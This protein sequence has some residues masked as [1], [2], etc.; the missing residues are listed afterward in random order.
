MVINHY[1]RALFTKQLLPQLKN[2]AQ[3]TPLGARVISVYAPGEEGPIFEDDLELKKNFSVTMAAKILT[4]Y[5][6]YTAEHL[7]KTNPDIGFSHAYP[8]VVMTGI[9]RDLPWYARMLL[10]LVSPFSISLEDS[11]QGF[12]WL[13]TRE[14][15]KT[16]LQLVDWK[17]KNMDTRNETGSLMSRIGPRGQ[18]GWWKEGLAEK[19]WNHTEEIFRRVLQS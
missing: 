17:G 7:S 2:G 13:A 1:G 8:S 10:P 16:G 4:A 12:L 6:T 9:G 15:G 3:T 18:N 19:V 14:E 11:A 5:Q